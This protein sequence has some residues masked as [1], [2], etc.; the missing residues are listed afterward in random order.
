MTQ[1]LFGGHAL[2]ISDGLADGGLADAVAL[3]RF[4]DAGKL[5]GIKEVFKVGQID[6]A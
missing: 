3:C 6:P 4:G 1:K 5:C 2:E